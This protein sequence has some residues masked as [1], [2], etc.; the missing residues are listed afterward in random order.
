MSTGY[1]PPNI[2]ALARHH[3]RGGTDVRDRVGYQLGLA[4]QGAY[5]THPDTTS[6][7]IVHEGTRGA[8]T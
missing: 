1:Q 7:W 6:F 4:A 5:Q 8:A 2:K 3:C